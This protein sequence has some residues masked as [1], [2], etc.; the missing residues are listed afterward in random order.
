MDCNR[1]GFMKILMALCTIFLS[2]SANADESS[3]PKFSAWMDSL[4]QGKYTKVAMTGVTEGEGIPCEVYLKKGAPDAYYLSIGVGYYLHSDTGRNHYF[5]SVMTAESAL[6]MTDRKVSL[7]FRG[8]YVEKGPNAKEWTRHLD[9][10]LEA[11]IELDADG[12]PFRASG[13]STLQPKRQVCILGEPL[14]S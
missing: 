11:D 12:K 10:E 7:S 14:I 8:P 4:L 2:F 5:G 1:C 3:F 6:K 13:Q 9:V